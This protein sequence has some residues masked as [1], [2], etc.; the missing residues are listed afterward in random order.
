MCYL[1]IDGGGTKTAF[2]LADEA[3]SILSRWETSTCDYQ[4]IGMENFKR[5]I[6]EGTEQV[7]REA[8]LSVSQLEHAC[9]GIPCYGEIKADAEPLTRAVEEVFQSVP[10]SCVND[11]EIAWYGS[12]GGRPGINILA[13]T[14]AMGYGRDALGHAARASGWGDFMGDEGSAYWL[15]KK[16]IELFTKQADGRLPRDVLYSIVREHFQLEDDFELIAISSSQLCGKRREVGKL[17]YLLYQAAEQ[18]SRQ[19]QLAY[20]QAAEELALILKA[21]L[22]QLSFEPGQPVPVSYSG[23]VFKAG[24]LL[25]EPLK[26]A[27]SSD[28][29]CFSEPLLSP[30]SGAVLAAF[31]HAQGPDGQ[32]GREAFLCRL[33]EQEQAETA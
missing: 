9:I 14:G 8:G 27:L 17:Q 4:Q 19:A 18:G 5:V 6:R 1:G 16:L 24:A 7:C 3:G 10:V 32:P 25:L 13:G 26:E 15:G 33:R 12:L 29:V 2:L 31:L 21:L 30:V 23:G 22:R 11:V 20:R 28:A